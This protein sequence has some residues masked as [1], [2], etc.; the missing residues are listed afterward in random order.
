MD[1]L[2]IVESNTALQREKS[3]ERNN[4]RTQLLNFKFPHWLIEEIDRLRASKIGH[5]SRSQWVLETLEN[6][7]NR[8]E[9]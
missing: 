4:S 9:D 7:V 2:K 6:V 8:G 5:M 3:L 1:Y